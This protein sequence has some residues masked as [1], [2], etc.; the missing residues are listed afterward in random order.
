MPLSFYM[1]RILIL[2]VNCICVNSFFFCKTW[3]INKNNVKISIRKSCFW[4]RDFLIC[5][6]RKFFLIIMAW[7]PSFVTLLKLI[8]NKKNTLITRC[9]NLTLMAERKILYAPIDYEVGF[10][11]IENDTSFCYIFIIHSFSRAHLNTN[12]CYSITQPF[13]SLI[14]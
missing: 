8:T 4:K 7:L 1:F 3:M 12:F 5:L 10:F 14:R 13:Y 2:F 9:S 11:R 6:L